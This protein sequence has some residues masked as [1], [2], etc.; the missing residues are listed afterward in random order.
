MDDPGFLLSTLGEK[1]HKVSKIRRT[2][3]KNLND[4]RLVLKLA[5]PFPLKS[6][7]KLR[8]KM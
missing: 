3:S 1:Y 6:G 7:V 8:M 4:S 5:L 2:K